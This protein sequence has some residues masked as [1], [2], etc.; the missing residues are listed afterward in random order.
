MGT[1]AYTEWLSSSVFCIREL[2]DE[3]A[4]LG[5]RLTFGLVFHSS[6][7]QPLSDLFLCSDFL[8]KTLPPSFFSVSPCPRALLFQPNNKQLCRKPLS[9]QITGEMRVEVNVFPSW[10]LAWGTNGMSVQGLLPP[11]E[12]MRSPGGGVGRR[13]PWDPQK[14][15]T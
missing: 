5:T 13:R 7:G 4:L 11:G 3:R 15:L 8:P 14:H 9:V 10:S 2:L 12:L 6:P 1:H